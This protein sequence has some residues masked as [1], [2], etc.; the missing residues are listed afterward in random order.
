MSSA[1][2]SLA[3]FRMMGPF[4]CSPLGVLRG[5]EDVKPTSDN[6]PVAH[7]V[8]RFYR[9]SE[10]ANLLLRN[11]T[12]RAARTNI[13][14]AA[15]AAFGCLTVG[16]RDR[17]DSPLWQSRTPTDAVSPSLVRKFRSPTSGPISSD[18][19]RGLSTSGTRPAV[20][21]QPRTRRPKSCSTRRG[22]RNRCNVT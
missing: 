10:V 15:K 22:S 20:L 17:A 14:K 19:P 3:L 5:A 7:Q 1:S 9:L 13:R 4:M 18:Q 6:D 8:K 16:S 21:Q 11:T 2:F 12:V